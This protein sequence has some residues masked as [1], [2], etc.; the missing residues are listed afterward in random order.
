MEEDMKDNDELAIINYPV[1][2]LFNNCQGLATTPHYL[3]SK[4]GEA[5]GTLTLGCQ[6]I[7]DP[8]PEP[9]KV[10]E[11]PPKIKE[12]APKPKEDHPQAKEEPPKPKEEPPKAKE[13]PPKPPVVVPEV[14][15][16]EPAPSVKVEEQKPVIKKDE[17]KPKVADKLPEQP[18][19]Q[20]KVEE[21]KVPPQP[22]AVVEDKKKPEVDLKQH[23]V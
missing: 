18:P 14:V 13:D 7:A 10:K 8:K 15:K 6:Y 9:P 22:L 21:K 23:P 20:P 5:V 3:F 4:T 2:L 19:A 12:E 17:T 16:K 11:E 1:T